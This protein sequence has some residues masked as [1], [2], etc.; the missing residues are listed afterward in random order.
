MIENVFDANGQ[1]FI[2]Y[3]N[4]FITIVKYISE[5]VLAFTTILYNIY[6]KINCFLLLL[7]EYYKV[8]GS[9]SYHIVYWL[10]TTLSLILINGKQLHKK[11][12][13]F[14]NLMH[15][16]EVNTKVLPGTK[17]TMMSPDSHIVF[18]HKLA[19]SY[20]ICPVPPLIKLK[21]L[22][23]RIITKPEFRFIPYYPCLN[24]YLYLLSSENSDCGAPKT[25]T[26]LNPMNAYYLFVL[27]PNTVYKGQKLIDAVRRGTIPISPRYFKFPS[28]MKSKLNSISPRMIRI[29]LS[30]LPIFFITSYLL[31]FNIKNISEQKK[32]IC[33]QVT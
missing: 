12:S 16:S 5:N 27:I 26:N 17:H 18:L 11:L 3:S 28:N 22:W 24:Q 23:F 30:I 9:P 4:H 2:V 13:W 21:K 31:C 14:L 7:Y 32:R 19:R 1:F 15:Q 6:D 25:C 10:V 29:I 8:P 33:N 20:R